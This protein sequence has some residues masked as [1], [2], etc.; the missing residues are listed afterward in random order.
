MP[1]RPPTVPPSA[2]RRRSPNWSRS[3]ANSKTAPPT[4]KTSLARYE[5]GIG[6]LRHCYGQLQNAEQRIR[7]LAG[8]T[9][10]GSPDLRPFEH[11][12]S[13]E[14]AKAAVRKPAK[15]TADPGRE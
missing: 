2:S 4:W 11:T 5:R 3:S 14:T 10:D 12:A 8:L 9:E 13:I 6:L 1:C 15:R 7:L